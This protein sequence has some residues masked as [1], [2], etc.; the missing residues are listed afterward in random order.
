[1][2]TTRSRAL[3]C[4]LTLTLVALAGCDA[5]DPAA[6]ADDAQSAPPAADATAAPD[7]AIPGQYIVVLSEQP[8]DDARRADLDAVVRDLSA[9]SDVE[10]RYTYAAALTGFSAQLSPEALAALEADP[11]VAYIEP[12]RMAHADGP[13]TQSPATWGIDRINQRNRPIDNTYSWQAS[14][15]GVTIYIIDTGV[16]IT[17]NEFGGRASSGYDFVDNDANADDPCNG[18]G[19]HVAGTAAGA[20]YGVAKDAEIVA[21]R[22]LP[23]SGS[24]PWDAVIAGVNWVTANHLSPAVANMSL[25]GS[26]YAP[27]DAAVTNSIASGVQYSLSA[28]N[29]FNANACNFSPARVA[30][31]MTIGASTSTDARAVFSNSGPCIDWF[32]PG[33]GITSAWN[34]SNTATNILDGTSM[35]APH[36]AGV[37]AMYL[38]VAPAASPAQ[39]RNVIFNATTKNIITNANSTNAHLL[40]NRRGG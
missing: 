15:E 24:G 40:Y 13:G 9:R 18:H 17:H 12:N 22:V 26:T 14:G 3:W 37:A 11:R 5:N 34:T 27:A 8:A 16:R 33:Q 32:A 30:A 20:T 35:A 36:S 1:M 31:A 10:V 21:V 2:P 19:T 23:C 29:S 28:G 7:D 39:V 6:L 4:A 38:E 25:G